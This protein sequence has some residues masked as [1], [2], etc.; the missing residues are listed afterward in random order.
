M[1]IFKPF[2][3]ILDCK[4]I[5][6]RTGLSKGY[7]GN[8][9]TLLISMLEQLLIITFKP[10]YMFIPHMIGLVCMYKDAQLYC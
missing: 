1:T 3:E 9:D 7:V 6:D 10:W 8:D 4:V 2:G 5:C